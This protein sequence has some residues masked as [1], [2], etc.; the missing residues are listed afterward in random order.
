MGFTCRVE[1]SI[2]GKTEYEKLERV[3]FKDVVLIFVEYIFDS[4]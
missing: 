1:T 4:Y 3:I 2:W